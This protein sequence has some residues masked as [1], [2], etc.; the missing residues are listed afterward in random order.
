MSITGVVIV[1]LFLFGLGLTLG[2]IFSTDQKVPVG[3]A[4]MVLIF[5]AVVG[6]IIKSL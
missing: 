4:G 5:V 3:I 6:V 1:G 2:D